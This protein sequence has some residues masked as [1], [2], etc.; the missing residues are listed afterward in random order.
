[1]NKNKYD[2]SYDFETDQ[3]EGKQTVYDY[4]DYGEM[5]AYDKDS[6]SP[7]CNEVCCTAGIYDNITGLYNLNARYCDLENGM[8]MTQD[9][10][11]GSRSR[12]ETL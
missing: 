11:R 8:F 7:F 10:Y 6:A 12:T 9:T 4:D 3:E 2:I 5:K 1:M